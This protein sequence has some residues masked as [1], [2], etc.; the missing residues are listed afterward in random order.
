M[1]NPDPD[2]PQASVLSGLPALLSIVS[3]GNGHIPKIK[4]RVKPK[5]GIVMHFPIS[6][7]RKSFIPEEERLT[8][9][10][11][12]YKVMKRCL[13]LEIDVDPTSDGIIP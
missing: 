5:E 8:S 10:A 6:K 7:E 13:D 3:R 2:I 12:V 11:L 4:M 1:D 9:S